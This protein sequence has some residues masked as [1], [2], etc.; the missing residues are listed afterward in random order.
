MET[1]KINIYKKIQKVKKE[2]SERELKK[3]GKN[4]FS[5]FE[6]YELNY[7]ISMDYLLKLIL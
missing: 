4:T 7:V 1:E 2:L 6:Y 5:G 3:S